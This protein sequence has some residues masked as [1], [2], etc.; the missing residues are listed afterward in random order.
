MNNR[1]NTL[2]TPG[3]RATMLLLLLAVAHCTYAQQNSM[4][5]LFGEDV[6]G[7]STE[8]RPGTTKQSVMA[9]TM[10]NSDQHGRIHFLRCDD[11]PGGNDY[12]GIIVSEVYDDP[13]YYDERAV[14]IVAPNDNEYY[15]TALVRED[16]G[17]IAIPYGGTTVYADKIKV[18]KVDNT[19]TIQAQTI[20][21]DN[22]QVASSTQWWG[23]SMYPTH[24]FYKSGVLDNGGAPHDILY[25][26]GFL[27]TDITL[28]GMPTF[29]TPKYAFIVG[30]DVNTF[31][32]TNYKFF[33]NAI[34]TTHSPEL[35]FDIAMRI[36][37][38]TMGSYTGQLFLTGSMTAKTGMYNGPPNYG[39]T[40]V[41]SATMKLVLDPWD[42]SINAGGNIVELGNQ[43]GY[44][45]SEYGVG[46]VQTNSGDDNYVISNMYATSPNCSGTEPGGWHNNAGFNDAPAEIAITHLQGNWIYSPQR[47]YFN[48]GWALD[49]LPSAA[50][51]LLGTNASNIAFIIAG[52]ANR[53]TQGC[54]HDQGIADRNIT[55]FLFDVEVEFST[56]G[57]VGGTLSY[58]PNSI[59]GSATAG[60]V[61]YPNQTPGTGDPSTVNNAY[62]NLGGGLSYVLWNPTFAKRNSISDDIVLNA[63]RFFDNGT[64]GAARLGLKTLFA[65]AT[66]LRMAPTSCTTD[67]CE[68]V[69]TDVAPE[70]VISSEATT[71]LDDDNSN[72]NPVTE[73]PDELGDCNLEGVYKPG[74][75]ATLISKLSEQ[76]GMR[77][78]PNPANQ[79]IK[80]YLGTGVASD[81]A[82]KITLMNM[83]GQVMTEL[84]NGGAFELKVNN[85]LQLPSVAAGVYIVQVYVNDVPTHTERLTIQQ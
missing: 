73:A 76:P 16:S 60:Q 70:G 9:G 72:S 57:A 6:K 24:S 18:L 71:T 40:C 2:H 68:P 23:Y 49:V 7:Y 34:T 84:Y 14:D 65:D 79:A 26:C 50:N 83:Y 56:A 21:M 27:T 32:I 62:A 54:T 10:F 28:G 22:S 47:I 81:N 63:P 38:I 61:F 77:I 48:T 36:C 67:V 4:W 51:P 85:S 20:I 46:L 42:F 37:D 12:P 31:T 64:V 35:D 80:I 17:P 53:G 41:R 3:L 25:I 1:E 45:R 74:K 29:L 55:P 78:Y 8:I 58:Y 5:W 52:M 30:L 13:D 59:P 33:D 82:V 11:G 15:I 19:G 39:Y 66:T 75:K 43:D 44:G 69:S